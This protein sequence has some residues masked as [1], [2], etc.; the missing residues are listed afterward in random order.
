MTSHVLGA[1]AAAV[2]IGAGCGSERAQ[3][4]SQGGTDAGQ[5]PSASDDTTKAIASVDPCGLV[6]KDEIRQQ[7][8][9]VGPA[10]QVAAL[11]N[12]GAV[13]TI[14]MQPVPRGVSRTCEVHS[15]ASI[16]GDV[17]RQDDFT[18]V[19]TFAGWLTGSVKAMDHPLP[20][21][22][23]GDEAYFVGGKSGPPYARVGS[24]AVGIENFPDT[25]LS[26]SGVDLLRL[27]VPRAHTA[28]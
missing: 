24:I 11:K 25:R 15:R 10:D 17:R 2:I 8:E 19:V 5:N 22:D 20:I 18:I 26:R 13:W 12:N 3:S 28:Q 23:L 16:A 14:G 27:A 6:T 9:L 4:Q 7:L 21:A 1:I